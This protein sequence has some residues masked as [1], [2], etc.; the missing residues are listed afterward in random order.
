MAEVR[1]S[2]TVLRLMRLLAAASLACA[3]LLAA[4]AASASA[5]VR[6]SIVSLAESQDQYGAAVA[7]SPANSGCNPYTGY[8]GDGPVCGA[9]LRANEWCADFAAWVWHQAGVSFTY[10]FSGSDI[11]AWSASFYF[12]GVATG[13]WHPLSS[14]YTP[15]AGDVAVY[16][17]LTEASG[18]GHVGIYVGGG[19]TSPTVVNGNWA[20]NWPDPANYG[21]MKQSGESNTGVAGGVLDGYVSPGEGGSGPAGE[22]AFISYAGNVYRIAGGAPIYVSNWAAF[23]GTQPTTPL[24]GEQ[25]GSLRQYPAD[26]TGLCGQQAGGIGGAFVVAGGA[27]IYITNFNN[28]DPSSCIPVDQAALNNAGGAGPYGHLRQY[29]EDGTG[30][31][32]QQAGGIGGAFVVAGGAPIYITNFNNVEPNPCVP[33]DQ[34]TLEHAGGG[35]WFSHLRQY[36]ED[37]TG[38][39]GQQAGGGGGAFVVAGGA[40]MYI[41]SF[42]HV[43][44]NPCVPVDQVTI[45]NAGGEGWFG[46]LRDQ[47]ANGTFLNS[48]TGGVYRVAGGAP[49]AVSSWGVF[50]GEQP[51]VTVDEWDI[52]NVT[53]PAAHLNATPANGTI[54]EGLPS[55]TDWIFE[56]GLRSPIPAN[57]AAVA[58]D[59]FGLAAYPV[60]GEPVSQSIG[61]VTSVAG[62]TSSS[63]QVQVRGAKT[64]HKAVTSRQRLA[65]ALVA[66]RKVKNRHERAKCETTAR[67][68][69]DHELQLTRQRAIAACK[70]IKNPAKQKA[71]VSDAERRYG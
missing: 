15:Q 4:Q 40:P 41:S 48:S 59:D 47:P 21:V 32:G 43:D 19:A 26:G 9:G 64:T 36:P 63:G 57:A 70:Q 7:D 30:L 50:G 11:N 22:G 44:P 14:G 54:V 16:G 8:W 53:N 5:D 71:C 42:S 46:H 35:G 55:D 20:V 51:Y 62:S 65:K 52:E 49:F 38:L 3:L 1:R 39:C 68:R 24:S 33:V 10:G 28:V 67:R 29:P 34:V 18:P 56:S 61:S 31:C 25:W 12:W 45:N 37:G 66:C 2:G 13:N 27:P 58:V 60:K 17:N 69:Y 6:S 23:G